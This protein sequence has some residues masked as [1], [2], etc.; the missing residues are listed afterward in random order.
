MKKLGKAL[1]ISFLPPSPILWLWTELSS[2]YI[3][4]CSCFLPSAQC[5]HM[6]TSGVVFLASGFGVTLGDVSWPNSAPCSAS[7]TAPCL[8][9]ICLA[10]QVGRNWLEQPLLLSLSVQILWE[11]YQILRSSMRLSLTIPS[12]IFSFC[13]LVIHM[14]ISYTIHFDTCFNFPLALFTVG[15]IH[16]LLPIMSLQ[17]TACPSS[18]GLFHV[19]PLC[20]LSQQ[21][22]LI[23]RFYDKSMKSG[24]L[25]EIWCSG[26]TCSV[27]CGSLALGAGRCGW[28]CQF[29]GGPLVLPPL[30]LS[31][32]LEGYR[33]G[34]P[35]KYINSSV[36]RC[37][38]HSKCSMSS[39]CDFFLSLN[40]EIYIKLN[41]RTYWNMFPGE[42]V[43]GF[44]DSESVPIRHFWMNWI[45]NWIVGFSTPWNCGIN[46]IKHSGHNK[47]KTFRTE[48]SWESLRDWMEGVKRKLLIISWLWL[49]TWP[50]FVSFLPPFP[51]SFEGLSW[52]WTK[53]QEII[54]I[55]RLCAYRY[56]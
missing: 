44:S 21:C 48:G 50:S 56:L 43:W 34:W 28:L 14:F 49:S 13:C 29:M 37:R 9:T 36:G 35:R 11:S 38:A 22:L 20:S 1:Q 39:N 51:S 27:V 42:F 5:L 4:P 33:E 46:A 30:H 8:A 15:I 31:P 3:L 41:K 19:L 26:D 2:S 47:K 52:K 7:W 17:E 53:D 45:L 12:G 23:W 55:F 18:P 24:L 6:D 25:R 16:H 40:F 54:D 10:A 32:H